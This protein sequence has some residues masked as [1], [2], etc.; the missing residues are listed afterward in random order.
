[1]QDYCMGKLLKILKRCGGV[2]TCG[3]S[4]AANDFTCGEISN[5]KDAEG[6]EDRKAFA[7][8]G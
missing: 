2:F 4:I 3:D 7:V 1:M 6:A 5:R 8:R